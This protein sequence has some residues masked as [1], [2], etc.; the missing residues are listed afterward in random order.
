MPARA[1]DAPRE[2]FTEALKDPNPAVVLRT[3]EIAGE[4]PWA[5][6]VA[7]LLDEARV[8]GL[9][10][11]EHKIRFAHA[12]RMWP[13]VVERHQDALLTVAQAP[14]VHIDFQRNLFR[15]VCATRKPTSATVTAC[16]KAMV[17]DP[18]S[19]VEA[20]LTESGAPAYMTVLFANLTSGGSMAAA[21]ARVLLSMHA[22]APSEA[23]RIVSQA[24]QSIDNDLRTAALK[25]ATHFHLK[26]PAASLDL[27]VKDTNAAVRAAAIVAFASQ[28]PPPEWTEILRTALQSEEP[29]VVDAALEVLAHDPE[30]TKELQDEV[31]ARLSDQ[32]SGDK[33]LPVIRLLPDH[34][35]EQK[36]LSRLKTVMRQ[37]KGSTPDDVYQF[38]S[39][40]PALAV[41]LKPTTVDDLNTA[42][43]STKNIGA[44]LNVVSDP[45]DTLPALIEQR[46]RQLIS[47]DEGEAF[48]NIL[49]YAPALT[50]RLGE[51]VVHL[52]QESPE[53][54]GAEIRWNI[55]A[56]LAHS[57]ATLT[58]AQQQTVWA[59]RNDP[60]RAQAVLQIVGQDKTFVVAHLNDFVSL[61][62]ADATWSI[63]SDLLLQHDL[64]AGQAATLHA[65][66]KVSDS[67]LGR[68]LRAL[69]AE[70]ALEKEFEPELRRALANDITANDA[71]QWLQQVPGDRCRLYAAEVVRL[72]LSDETVVYRTQV[73]NVVRK[74]G[75]LQAA[76]LVELLRLTHQDRSRVAEFR[77]WA[78][79]LTDAS[80]DAKHLLAW[81]GL[82]KTRPPLPQTS[83]RTTLLADLLKLWP[84][85]EQDKLLAPELSQAIDTVVTGC[86]WEVDDLKLL[87]TAA[88]ELEQRGFST[89]VLSV[90][91][92]TFKLKVKQW[93][94]RL[95]FGILGHIL[96]W[97]VLLAFYRRSSKVQAAILW[98]PWARSI[99][100][101]GYVS[102]LCIYVAPL[103]R[104]LLAPFAPHLRELPSAPSETQAGADASLA[105][106]FPDSFV[107]EIVKK[108]A[109]PPMRQ[110]VTQAIP[111]LQGALVVVGES[112]LGKTMFLRR[113]AG[114]SKRLVVCLSANE[115]KE[116][117]V[118]AIGARLPSGL[119]DDAFLRSIV[120]SGGLDVYVDG[121]NEVSPDT[122][123]R[124]IQFVETN[125]GTHVLLTTQ[126]LNDWAPPKRARMFE[127]LSLQPDQIEQFLVSRAPVVGIEAAQQERYRAACQNYVQRVLANDNG[128]DW[129]QSMQLVLSNP[130]DLTVVAE[131]LAK[132]HAP[133]LRALQ[134]QQYEVMATAYQKGTGRAFPLDTF[135][136]AVFEMRRKDLPDF[137]AGPFPQELASLEAHKMVRRRNTKAS[138]G[139]DVTLWFFRHDKV[140]EFFILQTFLKKGGED[141]P[142]KYLTD[143]RFRGVYFLLATQ[144]PLNLAQ[145]LREKLLLAAIKK[146]DHSVS[147][148]FIQILAGRTQ[149]EAE[150]PAWVSR[151]PLA[152]EPPMVEALQGVEA[153]MR[154]QQAKR[155]VLDQDLQQLRSLRRLL[156]VAREHEYHQALSLALT[157]LQASFVLQETP[158]EC[159]LVRN[160]RGRAFAVQSIVQ[161]TPLGVD[162][163]RVAIER[164]R[165]SLQVSGVAEAKIVVV[166]HQAGSAQLGKPLENLPLVI[167]QEATQQ[168]VCLVSSAQIFGLL[169]V[170]A[171]GSRDLDQVWNELGRA[172]G[173][174]HSL[175]P[176]L[177]NAAEAA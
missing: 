69:A 144:L 25:V 156:Y 18:S 75:P 128:E 85:V 52:I 170:V 162:D 67:H 54:T 139:K 148:Q 22:P 88:A 154:A 122:R 12:L 94:E 110:S 152:W 146:Q 89:G 53:A 5:P 29:V 169:Q 68:W 102:L 106:Y 164:A 107:Q 147:D 48:A 35:L 167:A 63:V 19:G 83:A 2:G 133:D 80:A 51:V 136:E 103:R 173:P 7:D 26:I 86:D 8:N 121:L 166:F 126:P 115:C 21:S 105:H 84:L 108:G 127:L 145:A 123:A 99:L 24:L 129:R 159:L 150:A 17:D 14:D 3:L 160:L 23:D 31:I 137:P 20:A 6:N 39:Q 92:V 90:N 13:A 30:R 11:S 113:T 134:Q 101:L 176:Y 58:S 60:P 65:D 118:E 157:K 36:V 109:R 161:A 42:A 168:D 66:M 81:L 112:G 172:A 100:G 1:S 111:E 37:G 104:L 59:L 124:I 56:R 91:Q 9:L 142:T 165:A 153:E 34:V 28:T 55:A 70:P 95:L 125:P 16:I 171:D 72:L 93:L 74:L 46:A 82:P 141:R 33:A 77:A 57:G 78:Y 38:L 151:Y 120:Y 158:G 98:N 87:S 119:K 79:L 117:V 73:L 140:T 4:Q 132:G 76:Q 97:V 43:S 116:G 135:S 96:F 64:L 61:L 15:S 47:S 174:L 32:F 27:L 175:E 41:R 138:D 50:R 71:I 155:D 45:A 49:H 40:N 143:A 114:A 130:M 62:T 44:F 10:A 163:F 177:D 131:L 149:G